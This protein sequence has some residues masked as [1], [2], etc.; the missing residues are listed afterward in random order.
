MLRNYSLATLF[1]SCVLLPVS[2]PGQV[3]FQQHAVA[4]GNVTTHADFNGDG[5]EDLVNGKTLLLSNGDGT[6]QAPINL[7]AS[8]DVVGDFN[9][10]GKLDFISYR[11][12]GSGVNESTTPTVYLGN[13][14]GTFQAGK[15][16]TGAGASVLGDIF[17]LVA[18]DF[19]HD[20]Q[21]DFVTVE[22]THGNGSNG[23]PTI[24]QMWLSNGDG[25]FTKG[26]SFTTEDPDP[27]NPNVELGGVYTGDFDGDGKPDLAIVYQLFTGPGIVQIWYGDGAGHLGPSYYLTD[28]HGYYEGVLTVAD[29]N[30]DGRDDLISGAVSL[31]AG[32][33]PSLQA[34]PMLALFAGNANRTLSYSNISTSQCA[35]QPAVADFNGDGLNDLAYNVSSCASYPAANGNMNLVFRPGESSG[36]FGQEQTIAQSVNGGF[37]LSAIRSTT[38]TKPDLLFNEVTSSTT[39][40]VTIELLTNDSTGAFPGCGLSGMAE[41]VQICSPAGTSSTSPVQFSVAAAGPTP[42]R[43]AAVW[44][45]GKKVAEQLTHAFSNYSFLDASVALAAGSHAVTIYGTGWDNTLQEKSFTLNVGSGGSCSAPT[46][47]G[48]HV[49]QPASGATVAT[50]VQIQATSTITGK[51]DRMEVWVDGVKKYTETSGTTLNTTLSLAAGSHRF[52]VFAVNTAGTKWEQVVYA[53]VQ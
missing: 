19:N 53:T 45:D 29:V 28:P 6:Y 23:Y 16:V 12:N 36:S 51:L 43:T 25:T 1:V 11:N 4:S 38:G 46:S 39:S 47:P 44:V 42:M 48:V 52:G 2:S 20:S 37:P 18:A 50:P 3:S 10:D 13:G 14:N 9:H 34:Y 41:G 26:Q 27:S 22:E 40:T 5:R 30:N 35:G 24:V 8:A 49:C 33:Y 32:R 21:T 17:Y 7:P 31:P 15:V